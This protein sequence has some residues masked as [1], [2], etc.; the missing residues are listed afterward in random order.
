VTVYRGTGAEDF[1]DELRKAVRDCPDG[2]DDV[3]Y[4][5]LGSFGSGDES[6]LI[7][8]SR[9][10]TDLP[11]DPVPGADPTLTYVAAARIGDTVAM[12]ECTGYE[13][14]GS[15]KATALK[16]AKIAAD[17]VAGWRG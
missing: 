6:L 11:G 5:S 4:R 13:N 3:K 15:E 16:L 17:R 10:T 14:W 1:L 2:G 8:R 7:E 12:V 9:P